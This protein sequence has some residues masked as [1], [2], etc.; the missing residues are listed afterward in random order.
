MIRYGLGILAATAGTLGLIALQ[1][2]SDENGGA[3]P[4]PPGGA[5]APGTGGG[6][7]VGGA[8]PGGN[9]GA[10]ATPATGS[11][12]VG[13]CCPT[14]KSCYSN[15]ATGNGSPGSECLATQD[16]TGQ[17][18]IQM[19]Q[20]WIRAVTP[21]GNSSGLVYAVLA[22]RTQL[23]WKACNQTGGIGSGGYIQLVD[24]FLGAPGSDISTHY[25]QVG[26]A[27]YVPG[28]ATPGDPAF[29][30]TDALTNGFCYG[31]E[32]YAGDANYR[33]AANQI[34]DGAGFPTGLP[35][36]M[37]LGAG[38]WKVG[39]SKAK[40]LAADFDIGKEGNRTA[41]QEAKRV[42]LLGKLDPAGEYGAAGFGGVFFFDDATGTSHGFGA[43][44]WVVVYDA[45]GATHIAIPIREV[46]LRSKFNDPKAPN[47]VGKYL[48]DALD[49]TTCSAGQ[50][51]TK[52]G[53]GG[54]DCTAS[55]G[56]A[57]CG[58]G[59]SAASTKGY[60]IISE[61]EQIYAPDLQSTL[62]VSYPGTDP[63]T[64]QPRVQAEGFYDAT[65]KGCLTSKWNPADPTNGLPKGDW[66]AKTNSPATADCHDSWRS[67]SFHAFA[68]AKIK[69]AGAAPEI[70]AF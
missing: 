46:E 25:S 70:C 47:C 55:T 69:L 16:N 41:D 49:Q 57:A 11:T 17:Q 5:G 38:A 23:P 36:P 56:T 15:P 32:D 62:C 3:P 35:K 59:E 33:L 52:P 9:G 54:G 67:I 48:P 53:W 61:L 63:A 39:P 21:A 65:R 14:E 45:T 37:A 24:F 64:S 29:V 34:G 4:L 30:P 1:G 60:F 2:C 10:G 66:C 40:R 68:G 28:P 19:R 42:E 8:N 31:S 12:C 20:Q 6:G 26:Y 58:P 22:G 18:H 44:G 13:T 7:P 43:L 51:P 50:D 27:K